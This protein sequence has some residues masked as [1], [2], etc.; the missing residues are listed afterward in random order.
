MVAKL[1]PMKVTLLGKP[2]PGPSSRMGR[3][4]V[5]TALTRYMN[6]LTGRRRDE[7]YDHERQARLQGEG[8]TEGSFS[9]ERQLSGG[10]SNYETGASDGS[11]Q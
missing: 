3:L 4:V 2:T 1:F 11:A 7:L 6:V 8:L 9:M 5:K 10:R